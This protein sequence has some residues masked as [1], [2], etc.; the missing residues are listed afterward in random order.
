MTSTVSIWILS[1]MLSWNGYGGMA[2]SNSDLP[3]Q[4]DNTLDI[5]GL[6]YHRFGDH[7]YP[8][9]NISPD[10]FEMHVKYLVQHNIPCITF[11]EAIKMLRDGT[12]TGRYCVLTIDDAFKSFYQKGFPILKKYNVK[13]TLFL[14][15]STLDG[16]DYMSS[17]HIKEVMEY[18]IEIG[19]H[20]HSHA[21]F[22]NYGEGQ[23]NTL[24]RADIKK[25]EDILFKTFGAIPVIFAYPYGE[26][27]PAMEKV[28]EEMGFIGAAAQNSGIMTTH[29]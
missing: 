22:L 25:A 11:S 15:T 17:D 13:A 7:Q 23:R 2:Q 4:D 29:P 19:N 27:D 1:I 10:L 12:Q 6:I 24:F 5:A 18:G 9:T 21:Y 26:Y 3:V 14:N 20:T 8:S 16:G 28:L